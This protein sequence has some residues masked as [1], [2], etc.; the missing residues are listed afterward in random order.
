MSESIGNNPQ[1]RKPDDL[2]NI[3]QQEQQPQRHASPLRKLMNS[4]LRDENIVESRHSDQQEKEDNPV[5]NESNLNANLASEVDPDISIADADADAN[6]DAEADVEDNPDIKQLHEV[7]YRL[8]GVRLK[9]WP[10]GNEAL[11]AMIT[12]KMEQEKTAQEEL[13]SK[14]LALSLDMLN[15]A[16]YLQIPPDLIPYLFVSTTAEQMREKLEELH[17]FQLQSQPQEDQRW[18]QQQQQQHTESQPQPQQQQQQ[19]QQQ[20]QEQHHRGSSSLSPISQPQQPLPSPQYAYQTPSHQQRHPSMNIVPHLPPAP[21][22]AST[23]TPAP[24]TTPQ[25][26][27]AEGYNSSNLQAKRQGSPVRSLGHQRS[28]TST[29]IPAAATTVWKVK[30]PQQQQFQF[31]HWSG[32]NTKDTV[33]TTVE[34]TSSSTAARSSVGSDSTPSSKR[35]LSDSN[36]QQQQQQQQSQTF[37]KTERSDS[38]HSAS[39][40]P[41]KQDTSIHKRNRSESSNSA[42][43]LGSP[44]IYRDTVG[45]VS[46]SSSHYQQSS[47]PQP[48]PPPPMSR[49]ATPTHLQQVQPPSSPYSALRQPSQPSSTTNAPHQ[50][51]Q[52]QQQAYY[53]SS[54]YSQQQPLP[55]PP[56]HQHQH[57][58]QPQPHQPQQQHLQSYS[59]PQPPPPQYQSQ[60][61]NQQPSS[62]N[63]HPFY[64]QQQQQQQQPYQVRGNTPLLT[65]LRG[66]N[67]VNQDNQR[68]EHDSSSNSPERGKAAFAMSSMKNPPQK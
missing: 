36:P 48:P 6:V 2:R 26:R 30:I 33:V 4:P 12:L 41:S 10:Y 57:Q 67:V 40:S 42:A 50:Y 21:T 16:R 29:G 54:P 24:A 47:R 53:Y 11:K 46:Y 58:P 52:Q 8:L 22:P 45:G 14:S 60:Q 28:H 15:H 18:K 20:E 17:R 62:E 66:P 27:P 35:K 39:L 63:L 49:F 32:P 23:Q 61:H 31:H 59:F 44:Y 25:T 68:R 34:G 37:L 19:H 9:Q 65:P 3:Q 56:P 7:F 64:A 1:T 43:V 13:R 55:P 51:Q 38:N 5:K